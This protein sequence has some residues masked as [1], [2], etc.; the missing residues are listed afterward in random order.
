MTM[1]KQEPQPGIDDGVASVLIVD[2]KPEWAEFLV[3]LF[4]SQTGEWIA[5]SAGSLREGIQ[6][7][8]ERVGR[9]QDWHS[10]L[11]GTNSESPELVRVSA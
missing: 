1:A 10:T 8:S 4:R 3:Q 2:D 6:R 7:L 9:R 5:N 11:F